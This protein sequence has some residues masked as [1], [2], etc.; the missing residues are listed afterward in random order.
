MF[1]IGLSEEALLEYIY[2]GTSRRLASTVT[3]A[4]QH[5]RDSHDGSTRS[6]GVGPADCVAECATI[7]AGAFAFCCLAFADPMRSRTPN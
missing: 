4:G 5:R 6:A 2:C 1:G 7:V 3:L